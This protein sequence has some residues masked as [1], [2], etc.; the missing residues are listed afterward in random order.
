MSFVYTMT[1]FSGP[2]GTEIIPVHGLGNDTVTVVVVN[3]TVSQIQVMR[4]GARTVD[5]VQVGTPVAA[6]RA[7]RGAVVGTD[8]GA[9]TVRLPHECGIIFST[10][11]SSAHSGVPRGKAPLPFAADSA[12]IRT[13]IVGKCTGA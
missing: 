9:T 7:R 12:V 8:G 10:A 1:D 4:P 6:L 2:D 11:D 13:I 3:D 5:G